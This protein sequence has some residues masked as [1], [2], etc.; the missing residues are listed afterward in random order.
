MKD[1]VAIALIGSGYGGCLHAAGY[2][3]VPGVGVRLKYIVDIDL[4]KA[5]AFAQA[6]GIERATSDLDRALKD[7]EVDIIDIVTPPASHA[8][9][10]M[11]AAKASKSVVCEKPL[12][13][14]FGQAGDR[15]PVGRVAKKKMYAAVLKDLEALEAAVK[16]NGTKF[17][18]AENYVY[19]PNVQK[20]AE[21]ITR[22]KSKIL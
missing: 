20:T 9:L 11:L 3:N 6:H 12:T 18:Y 1:R 17:M 22:K 21:I 8:E 5:K 19:S 15:Q 14:Y 4:D 16:A 7:P 13:G 2:R 10:V